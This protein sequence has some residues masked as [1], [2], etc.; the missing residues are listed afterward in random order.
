MSNHI[1]GLHHVTAI[2]GGAQ[3]NLDF[4]AK[5][6]GLRFVKKTVNFDDPGTYHLYYG[7]ETGSAGTIMTF[8]PWENARAGRIGAGQVSLTQFAVPAGALPFWAERLPAM[9]ATHTG[10]DTLFGEARSLWTDPDGLAFALVEMADDTRTP[11]PADGIPAGHAIRGFRGVTL[12]LR[13]GE[14]ERTILTEVFDYAVTG[15]EGRV[16]RLTTTHAGAAE[17]VDLHI[18]PEM[19]MGV[20]GG[21]SVHHVAFSVKDRAAQMAVRARMEAAGMRVTQ[22]IDRDYFWAIY[23]RT[24]GGILFEVATEEPG[25]AADEPVESLGQALK[26][27]TQHEPMRARIEAV[28]PK[29]S[30]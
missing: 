7:D 6:L 21:G 24:P 5:A 1:Q 17:I 11:W 27:P 13:D 26:L 14:A 28:L 4:Y 3:R 8:F 23:S 22:Q 29:L 19:P 15:Q 25:F 9:G 12:A 16:T 10:D 20:E 30:V 2:S 18:D